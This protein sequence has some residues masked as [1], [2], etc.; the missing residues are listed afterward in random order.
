MCSAQGSRVQGGYFRTE[1]RTYW[2]GE[3]GKLVKG[4]PLPTMKTQA[5]PRPEHRRAGHRATMGNDPEHGGHLGRERAY[6]AH[7]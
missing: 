6:R 1:G 5:Q 7:R 2:Q 3:M 4:W